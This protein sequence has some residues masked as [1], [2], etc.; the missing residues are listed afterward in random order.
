MLVVGILYRIHGDHAVTTAML[1]GV[2][3]AAAGL[4]LATVIQL[5][6]KSLSQ[7]YDLIF[8]VITVLAVNRL[9]QSVP[10]TLIVV[11][12]AAILWHY[13]RKAAKESAN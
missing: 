5:G 11:G 12:L 13:P 1:K 4:L 2:A 7:H 10:R 8:V 3:A 6:K 9:H